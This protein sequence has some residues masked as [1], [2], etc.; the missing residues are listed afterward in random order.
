MLSFWRYPSEA[1]LNPA[2][3]KEALILCQTLSSKSDQY[4]VKKLWELRKVRCA[5]N[6]QQP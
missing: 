6:Q 4:L 3:A 2:P 5:S 1:S